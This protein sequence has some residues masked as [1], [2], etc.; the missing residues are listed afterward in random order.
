MPVNHMSTFLPEY[1][2]TI[3]AATNAGLAAVLTYLAKTDDIEDDAEDPE[4]PADAARADI[5]ELGLPEAE[6][7]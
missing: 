6:A 2:P 5:G 1:E 7:R 4:D 3:K